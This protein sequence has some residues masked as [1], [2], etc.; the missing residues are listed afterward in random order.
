MTLGM[1]KELDQYTFHIE[2]VPQIY[3]GCILLAALP[4]DKEDIRNILVMGVNMPVFHRV[5]T[6]FHSSNSLTYMKVLMWQNNLKLRELDL[7]TV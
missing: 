2:Y 6:H 4:D 7:G 3:I 1:N 5:A